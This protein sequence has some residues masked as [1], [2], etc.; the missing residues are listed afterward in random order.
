MKSFNLKAGL[1]ILI[2]F[3]LVVTLNAFTP[4]EKFTTLKFRYNLNTET[5]IN[6]PSNWTD[7][8]N[9]S[10]PSGCGGDDI[11]CLLQFDSSEYA[12]LSAYLTANPTASDMDDSGKVI[13]HKA[14]Q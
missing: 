4:S 3:G 10:N 1:A 11:P 14:E 5:G 6:N 12:N 9:V 8:S 2:G 7:V 13:S